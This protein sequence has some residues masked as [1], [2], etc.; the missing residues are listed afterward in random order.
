MPRMPIYKDPNK[1]LHCHVLGTCVAALL[2]LDGSAVCL[3]RTRG[4]KKRSIRLTIPKREW[5]R[6]CQWAW[7]TD[8]HGREFKDTNTNVFLHTT[9]C[10]S[11]FDLAVSA[12]SERHCVFRLVTKYLKVLGVK[13]WQGLKIQAPQSV[14]T[15]SSYIP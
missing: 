9:H 13:G 6:D 5:R 11:V 7:A 1:V 8:V 12:A 15:S 4:S 10:L 2:F 14:S 3:L